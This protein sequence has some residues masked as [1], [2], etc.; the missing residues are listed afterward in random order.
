MVTAGVEKHNLMFGFKARTS[1]E[2][3]TEKTTFLLRLRDDENGREGVGEIPVFPSL[4]P[5]F[6]SWDA[7]EDDIREIAKII[8][9]YI[10]N[11]DLLPYNSAIRFGVESALADLN[12]SSLKE[13]V[14]IRI[15][16]LI[17][18]SDI[19]DMLG[20]IETKLNQGFSCIKLKIGAN[21]FDSEIDLIRTVR[22]TYGPNALEIRVDA[23][24]AFDDKDVLPMLERLSRLSVHSIEQPLSRD[25]KR[26]SELCRVSPLP[27]ALDEDMIERWW[28]PERKAEWLA[29]VSPQYIVVKPSLIGGFNAADNWIDIADGL[30]IGWWCT[31]A[32]ESNI[33]LTAIARWLTSRT[34][35]DT[36]THGLGTGQIYI[37]NF[38]APIRLE[39]EMLYLES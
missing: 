39:G 22:T 23:N 24:G 10:L 21:D 17:W 36:R 6:T 2:V 32:L 5:S 16:G 26:M 8:N 34:D 14:N 12:R 38:Q 7:I 3:F 37:N 18:M 11:P 27:I 25:H 19:D 13:P 20:Q 35:K 9:K 30:G 4:Q 15:N 29:R 1:R 28:E 31:S 33:G